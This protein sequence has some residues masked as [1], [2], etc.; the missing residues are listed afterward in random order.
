MHPEVEVTEIILTEIL[1]LV[2]WLLAS[3]KCGSLSDL[4]F[5]SAIG[6][7]FGFLSRSWEGSGCSFFTYL[8]LFIFKSMLFYLVFN[9]LLMKYFLVLW[10]T[11]IDS[12]QTKIWWKSRPAYRY[13]YM[14]PKKF[15]LPI[16]NL[17]IFLYSWFKFYLSLTE[18]C[19]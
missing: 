12:K 5:L 14:E 11:E 1:R 2:W 17:D 10:N 16:R 18:F 8:P 13:G 4:R 9:C 3:Y 6:L 19:N 7:A 15:C